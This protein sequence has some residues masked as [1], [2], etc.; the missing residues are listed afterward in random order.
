MEQQLL[1][2]YQSIFADKSDQH[3]FWSFM[4]TIN[5]LTAK[6]AKIF[7]ARSSFLGMSNSQDMN[8]QETGFHF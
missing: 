5:G 8:K 1:T 7:V 2:T 6:T 3:Q 4:Q